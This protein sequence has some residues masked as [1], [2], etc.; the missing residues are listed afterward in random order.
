VAPIV[1]VVW[2]SAP[3]SAS[4]SST[5]NSDASS[6]S[7]GPE[8]FL[9]ANFGSSYLLVGTGNACLLVGEDKAGIVTLNN[10]VC[11]F[12]MLSLPGSSIHTSV[13][14]T[15][16]GYGCCYCLWMFTLCREPLVIALWLIST[17]LVYSFSCSESLLSGSNFS[18][19]MDTAGVS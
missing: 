6:T 3:S 2:L 1:L 18:M 10:Y 4:G 19:S 5:F 17:R 12:C 9:C 15:E 11:E 13:S 7:M 8:A 16:S 14:T